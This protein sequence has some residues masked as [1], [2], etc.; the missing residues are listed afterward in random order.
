MAMFVLIITIDYELP[1]DKRPDVRSHMIRPTNSLLNIVQ[2]YGAKLTIM[3]EM[4]EIWAFEREENFGFN[5]YLGYDP[6]TEIRNQLEQAIRLGHDVQ[7][8]LHPQWLDA[9][10]GKNG[11][12]LRFFQISN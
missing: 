6:S 2:K 5:E 10:W 9:R 4:A 11:W 3:A 1:Y 8:H 7:L 12:Q